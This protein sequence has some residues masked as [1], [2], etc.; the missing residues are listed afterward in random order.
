MQFNALALLTLAATALAMPAADALGNTPLL[1][2]NPHRPLP[3]YVGEKC[4]CRN[5]GC[6]LRVG[7]AGVLARCD[8][9]SNSFTCNWFMNAGAGTVQGTNKIDYN[10]FEYTVAARGGC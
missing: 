9:L 3:K 7:E 6:E 8:S 5:A 10:G 4:C 1:S 2:S